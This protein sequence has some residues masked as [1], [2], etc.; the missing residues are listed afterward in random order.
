LKALDFKQCENHSR[1]DRILS[2]IDRIDEHEAFRPIQ[3]DQG[4]SQQK[5][6]FPAKPKAATRALISASALEP[7]RPPIIPHQPSFEKMAEFEFRLIQARPEVAYEKTEGSHGDPFA[8]S[9]YLIGSDAKYNASYVDKQSEI[10]ETLRCDI[11][12]HEAFLRATT[13]YD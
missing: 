10:C 5:P 3:R 2:L 8:E 11:D 4:I 6:K 12:G 9:T 1:D 13:P 7:I